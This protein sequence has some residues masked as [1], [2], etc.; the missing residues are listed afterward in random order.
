MFVTLM[1]ALNPKMLQR[2]LTLQNEHCEL[3]KVFENVCLQEKP[4]DLYIDRA[5]VSLVNQSNV[6]LL[7]LLARLYFM[8]VYS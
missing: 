2:R 5:H 7:H 6:K 8:G 4:M 1:R 3:L